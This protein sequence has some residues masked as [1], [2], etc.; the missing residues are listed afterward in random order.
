V[1]DH[2]EVKALKEA[3]LYEAV[4]GDM[5]KCNL[6]ARRCVIKEGQSGFCRV[7]KNINGKL[8]SLVYGKAVSAAVDP[9]EKKPLFHFHP[10]S[11]VMSIATVGCNFRC[12]FCDN[13]VISQEEEIYGKNLPPSR[14]VELALKYNC[15]GISYTYTEPTIFFEY[16][17][18]TAKIAKEKGLFNTFVTNGYMTPEAIKTIATYLDAATVDFKG[19]ANPEFYRK[20]SAVPSVEPI[21]ESLMEMKRQGIFIEITNLIV[22]KYGDSMED[23]RKL[24]KWIVDNLGPETPFHILRF[25]PDYQLID[26]PST[27]LET[28][29]KAREIALEEGLHYVYIGNV[30]GHEGENTYC[31]NCGELLIERYGFTILNWKITSNGKCPNCGYKLN[32]IGEYHSRGF[33]QYVVL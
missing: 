32:I 30:P 9:I 6:C 29:I 15:Q 3:M 19:S 14:V 16:A 10:G 26:V 27:P 1:Q 2:T 4:E 18:E 23:L 11:S 17:Y 21:F 5:V 7:R 22:P 33:Q 31:P 8:Y 13:W 25:H 12:K 24:A 28:L 20:I